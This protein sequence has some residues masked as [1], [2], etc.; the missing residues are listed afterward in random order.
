MSDKGQKRLRPK[1]GPEAFKDRVIG[2]PIDF[3]PRKKLPVRRL[4]LQRV[5]SLRA[6]SNSD[7]EALLKPDK[8]ANE[9]ARIITLEITEIWERAAIPCRRVDKVQK[10]VQKCISELSSLMKNWS[11][12]DEGRDPLQSYMS[13][14][15]KL[16][17][18]SPADLYHKL[19]TSGNPEW[20]EDWMF[21]EGQCSVPQ[22]GSMAGRDKL[23]QERHQRRQDRE[24]QA[25]ARRQKEAK[26]QP[27]AVKRSVSKKTVTSQDVDLGAPGYYLREVPQTN[28]DESEYVYISILHSTI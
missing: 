24:L 11:I 25:E 10:L 3:I 27:Q 18:I 13:S 6:Q 5:R 4:I 14:L 1:E 9:I 21:Y 19:K 22:A 15:D 26:G 17:D 16:F 20:I 2:K 8:T 28:Y 7:K 12:H 23:L